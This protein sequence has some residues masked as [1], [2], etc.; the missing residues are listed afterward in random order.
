MISNSAVSAHRDF[1]LT[2]AE[3]G[4]VLKQWVIILMYQMAPLSGIVV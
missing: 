3:V 2:S 1:K 4:L